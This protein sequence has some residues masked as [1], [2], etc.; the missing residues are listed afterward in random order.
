MLYVGYTI[1]SIAHQSWG[2]Q[3]ASGYDERSRLYGWRE[4]FVISGMG[5]VLAI[6][7]AVEMLGEAALT[8]KVASMGLFCLFCFL[9]PRYLHYFLYPT[10]RTTNPHRLIGGRH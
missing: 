4:I 2:A 10:S 9:L 8:T 7:V 6:P 5:L 3:L 1:L